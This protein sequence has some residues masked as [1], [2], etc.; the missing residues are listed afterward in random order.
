MAFDQPSNI[1]QQSFDYIVE[2][3]FWADLVLNFLKEYKDPETYETV[4]DI[5]RIAKRYIFRYNP[6]LLSKSIEV[7]SS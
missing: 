5:K 1:G 3:F 7:H 4:R 2:G 6:S